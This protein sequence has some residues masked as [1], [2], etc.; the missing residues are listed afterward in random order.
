[1]LDISFFI[2]YIFGSVATVL[3]KPGILWEVNI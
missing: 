1:M 3:I 2:I